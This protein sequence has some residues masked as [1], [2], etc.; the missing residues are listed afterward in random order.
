VGSAK[1]IQ[2]TP[3]YMYFV[4][5]TMSVSSHT[6]DPRAAQTPAELG[7]DVARVIVSI[8]PSDEFFPFT[9]A[10]SFHSSGTRNEILVATIKGNAAQS[11]LRV[12]NLMMIVLSVFAFKCAL[13][14]CCYW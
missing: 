8:P 11:A 4:S 10:V 2:V 14:C 9:I 13:G 7:S 6:F 5:Q 3:L 1:V 12:V